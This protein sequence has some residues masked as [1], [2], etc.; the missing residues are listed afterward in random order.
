MRRNRWSTK[1]LIFLIILGMIM[2]GVL[3]ESFKEKLQF[4]SSGINIGFSPFTLDLYFLNLTF[5][6]NIRFNLGSVIGILL[7][8][9]FYSL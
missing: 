8:L 7:V 1:F 2:G 6:L 4:L 9:V 3:A 5:G